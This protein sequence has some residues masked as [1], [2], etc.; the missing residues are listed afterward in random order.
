MKTEDIKAY[1]NKATDW[2][3]NAY[4]TIVDSKAARFLHDARKQIGCIV[5]LATICAGCYYIIY[6]VYDYFS[7]EEEVITLEDTPISI[8]AV[9]PKGELYVC[10][11]VIEDYVTL[12][13]TEHRFGIFPI[14][15]SCVQ[16]LRQKVSYLIDL[17]KVEYTFDPNDDHKVLVKLPP[18]EYMATTQSSPFMSD[19]ETYWHNNMPSTNGLKQQVEKKI[20]NRFDTSTNQKKAEIYAESA[21]SNILKQMGYE[22]MFINSV[23]SSQGGR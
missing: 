14:D 22:A 17:D 9:R 18:L 13:R 8:E 4:Y 11:S 6:K 21:I 1:I 23:S 15:H 5:V 7:A 19:N 12:Q 2:V 3:K 10:S 20:R 16:I